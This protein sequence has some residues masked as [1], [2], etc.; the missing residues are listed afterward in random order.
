MKL[1]PWTYRTAPGLEHLARAHSKRAASTFQVRQ[2]GF[3]DLQVVWGCLVVFSDWVPGHIL[4]VRPRHSKSGNE[5]FLTCKSFEDVWWSSR[6]RFADSLELEFPTSSETSSFATLSNRTLWTNRYPYLARRYRPPCFAFPQGSFASYWIV[7]DRHICSP[8]TTCS[9]AHTKSPLS[10][11]CHIMGS[12]R[13][14]NPTLHAAVDESAFR[15]TMIP[16]T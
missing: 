4:S 13:K 10:F 8:L 7:E 5:G 9:Q 15:T 11:S 16:V 2:W 14:T 3:P 12:I 6:I 1:L